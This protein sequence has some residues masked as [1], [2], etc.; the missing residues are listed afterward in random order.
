VLKSLAHVC[1]K[2]RDLEKTA[3]FYCGALG[4]TRRFEFSK[5]GRVI[6][7]YLK[8]ANDTF[9]EVFLDENADPGAAR[10]VLNH[11]CFETGDIEAVR[12][13]LL[14]RGYAPGEIIPGA[15]GALQF[16]ASD[17]NGLAIEFQQYGAQSSQRTGQAVI[18]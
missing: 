7:F 6:G 12:R 3:D 2:T 5:D 8:S 17:P 10:P 9:L 18:L 16:W 14:E 15:D 13:A 4:L 11:F 1:L